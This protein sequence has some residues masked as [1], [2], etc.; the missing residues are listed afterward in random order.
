MGK[1]IVRHLPAVQVGRVRRQ[2]SLTARVRATVEV[3]EEEGASSRTLA[4]GIRGKL[5]TTGMALVEVAVGEDMAAVPMVVERAKEVGHL[6]ER[7]GC[8][9]HSGRADLDK[10]EYHCWSVYNVSTC[11]MWSVGVTCSGRIHEVGLD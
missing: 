1:A 9:A 7:E 3:R 8:Q 6:V 10:V 5:V 2:P 4:R 11:E